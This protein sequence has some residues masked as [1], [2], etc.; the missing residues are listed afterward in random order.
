MRQS[1]VVSG[2]SGEALVA[3]RLRQCFDERN[4]V[5]EQ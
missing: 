4:V 1:S 3:D 5:L 2:A